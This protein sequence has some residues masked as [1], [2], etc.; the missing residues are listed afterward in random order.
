MKMNNFTYSDHLEHHGIQGMKWGIRRYQN[1]DGSYTQRGVA[2][3]KKSEAKYD[4]INDAYQAAK[5]KPDNKAE[6]KRLR[7]ERRVAKREMSKDYDRLKLDKRADQ[8]KQL[9][10]E[11]K[12]ITDNAQKAQMRQTGVMLASMAAGY[13]LKDRQLLTKYGLMP[14][15]QLAPATIAV[16]GTAV[17]AMLTMKERSENKKLRA[18]YAH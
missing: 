3:Y 8:G 1:Y 15:G 18:Y 10:K 11:G 6:I 13:A 4:S 7:S 2:R 5:N 12:T 16:G 9:Y 17:N 14:L